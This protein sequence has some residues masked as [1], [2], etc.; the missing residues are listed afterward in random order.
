MSHLVTTRSGCGLRDGTGLIGESIT[1]GPVHTTFQGHDAQ[2]TRPNEDLTI[3][4]TRILLAARARG[5]DPTEP[6][7]NIGRVFRPEWKWLDWT[8]Q[9]HI[10][11]D[12]TA[13]TQTTPLVIVGCG[14]A[15][16]DTPTESAHLYTGSYF[17]LALRAARSL[18]SEDRIRVMSARHGFV[19]LHQVLAP[20]NLRLGQ[21]GSVSAIQLSK[22]A[23]RLWLHNCD[24]VTVLAGR[25]YTQLAQQ[26][27]PHAKAPLAGTRGIGDQQHLLAAMAQHSAA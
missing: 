4:P 21:P 6:G 25:D 12:S 24:D 23:R 8:V 9:Q 3:W 13:N 10:N 19:G 22:Q 2:H 27:W 14:A 5:I 11:Y 20:Y 1:I 16:A 26:V 15:K 7:P 17:Q 18:V